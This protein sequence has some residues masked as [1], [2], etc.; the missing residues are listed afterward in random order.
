MCSG[1][2]VGGGGGESAS[3]DRLITPGE[4]NSEQ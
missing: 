4:V 3:A 2:G 1:V